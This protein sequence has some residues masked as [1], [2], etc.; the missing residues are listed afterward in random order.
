MA[1]VDGGWGS[2]TWAE[3]AWGCSVYYPL[4]AN[5]GW[6]LGAW[7]SDGWGLGNDG[8]VT[9]TD[10]AS[11]SLTSARV[12]FETIAI[13]DA[14]STTRTMPVNTQETIVG[15]DIAVGGFGAAVSVVETAATTEQISASAF[16]VALTQDTSTATEFTFSAP[17]YKC[18]VSELLSTTS[19]V[20][21]GV[22][23]G[24][25]ITEFSTLLDNANVTRT[26]V[27][28]I[29]E[30]T[31]VAATIFTI[32]NCAVSIVVNAVAVDQTATLV[33]VNS[34]VSTTVAIADVVNRRLLWEPI[35]TGVDEDWTLIN[36]NL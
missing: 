23:L 5:A 15:A 11:T 19:V 6:G 35:D 18:D 33:N 32:A 22:S 34:T 12:I 31:A 13:N 30:S 1:V 8:I 14:V 21:S 20:A 25:A 4:V 10:R 7:G 3:A 16:F 9:A 36:T 28:E 29:T 2:G 24:A 26:T 27:G 17:E